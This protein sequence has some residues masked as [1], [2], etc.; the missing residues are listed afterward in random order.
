MVERWELGEQRSPESWPR[1]KSFNEPRVFLALRLIAEGGARGR[2][3]G[4]V[5]RPVRWERPYV[6]VGPQRLLDGGL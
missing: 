2:I 1:G 5:G 6:R 4:G 3:A